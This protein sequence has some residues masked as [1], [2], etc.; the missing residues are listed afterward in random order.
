MGVHVD[1]FA[2]RGT[3]RHRLTAQSDCDVLSL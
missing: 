3:G 2:S 1:G